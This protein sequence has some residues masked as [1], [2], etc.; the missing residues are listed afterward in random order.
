MQIFQMQEGH[1]AK[2]KTIHFQGEKKTT[3]VI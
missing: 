3:T 2:V 1:L